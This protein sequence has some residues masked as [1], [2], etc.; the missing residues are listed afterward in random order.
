MVEDAIDKLVRLIRI[1]IGDKAGRVDRVDG[2]HRQ[3][4]TF[5]ENGRFPGG[6]PGLAYARLAD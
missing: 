3:H 2:E 4:A 1:D 5:R 6:E